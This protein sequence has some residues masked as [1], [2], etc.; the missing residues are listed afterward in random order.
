VRVAFTSDIAATPTVGFTLVSSVTMDTRQ[1]HLYQIQAV[2]NA[3]NESALF[4]AL[5]I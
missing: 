4:G 3:G 5:R 2:D 1:E